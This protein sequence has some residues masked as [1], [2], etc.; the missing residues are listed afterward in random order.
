MKKKGFL[1]A[2]IMICVTLFGLGVAYAAEV[3]Y[4]SY[5]DMPAGITWT[6]AE[7][8]YDY[9]NQKISFYPTSLTSFQNDNTGNPVTYCD[10]LLEKKGWIFWSDASSGT[11]AM[12]ETGRTY[13]ME[14]GNNGSGKFR[15]TF[16]TGTA[17]LP[18]GAFY[19]DPVYMY[20]YQ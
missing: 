1:I 14:M 7:R 13:S 5:L 16:S 12:R 19:A 2:T 9:A 17:Q 20:G 11:M 4:T 6:G 15:Y 8:N 18:L 3:R 10:I